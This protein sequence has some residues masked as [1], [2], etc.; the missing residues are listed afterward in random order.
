M[1]NIERG[2]E[3]FYPIPKGTL[4]KAAELFDSCSGLPRRLHVSMNRGGVPHIEFTLPSY[5]SAVPREK[6]K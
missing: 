6:G 1:S 5:Q 2:R 4:E 3:E